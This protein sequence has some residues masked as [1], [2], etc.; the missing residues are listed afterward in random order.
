M[1]YMD[2]TIMFKM[3]DFFIRCHEVHS[4]R[5]RLCKKDPVK[6]IPV[7]ILVAIQYKVVC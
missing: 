5:D 2:D 6:R 4:F 1:L 3:G 7:L